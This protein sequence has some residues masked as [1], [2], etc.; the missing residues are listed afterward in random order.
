[1]P[2]SVNLFAVSTSHP[3]E[4]IINGEL[5]RQVSNFTNYYVSV[6]GKVFSF[7][8]REMRQL[9]YSL[10]NKGYQ[11]LALCNSVTVK[12]FR[13][14]RLVALCFIENPNNHPCVR[15][16]DGNPSNNS[17]ENLAWGTY[18]DNEDDKL[19]HGTWESRRNGKLTKQMRDEAFRLKSKFMTDQKIADLF[20]VSRPTIT[21]LLNGRTWS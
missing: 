14:H 3:I 12:K 7:C 16:L 18:H 4:K 5:C 9:S 10:D 1:M 15:H 13:V 6:T 11:C 8:R 17:V 19:R 2:A 21:R 20:G